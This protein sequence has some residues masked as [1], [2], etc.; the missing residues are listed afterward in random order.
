MASLPRNQLRALFPDSA[1]FVNRTGTGPRSL[2][3]L[4]AVLA[5]TR[6]RGYAVE[7]GEVSPGLTSVA[8]AVHDHNRHPIAAVAVTYTGQAGRVALPGLAGRVE[9]TAAELTRRIEG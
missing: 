8:V 6:R 7:D 2:T 9:A 5:D 1:S 4:H 3:A